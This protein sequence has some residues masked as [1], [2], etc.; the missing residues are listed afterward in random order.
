MTTN[1]VYIK[2]L[3]I[4]SLSM[5]LIITLFIFSEKKV[6]RNNAFTRRYPPHPIIKQ[7]DLDI[8]Y[9]SYYIAGFDQ[10]FLYLGNRSTPWNLLQINMETR[11]TLTISLEPL[12]KKLQYRSIRI[13]VLSPH[14]FIMDGTMPFILRGRLGNWKANNWMEGAP[15]FNK[16]V[17]IDSNQIFIQAVSSET[18]KSALGMIKKKSSYQIHLDTTLLES[19]IDGIFDVDG[20]MVLSKETSTIGYVYYYRNQFMTMNFEMNN[21]KRNRTIDTVQKAQISIAEKNKRGQVTLKSPPL[22]INK[23]ACMSQ[24]LLLIASDRLGK[25]ENDEMLDE[26]TII[27]VYDYGRGTYE[28]SFYLYHTKDHRA[29]EFFVYKGRLIALTETL[30]TIYQTREPFFNEPLPNMITSDQ[31]LKAYLLASSGG[32]SKTRMI[33]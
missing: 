1:N 23:S 2:L 3:G 12:D 21:L 24:N 19:Q 29:R 11:D 7:Y 14:F 9:N 6:H 4:M 31:K 27:D 30:V 28:F 18:Q 17:P 26:A 16:A 33:E 8:G 10:N 32:R 13:V 20:I 5:G 15:F 25:N 22:F